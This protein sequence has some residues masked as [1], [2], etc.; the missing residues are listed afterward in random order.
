MAA[1]EPDDDLDAEDED[2]EGYYE[3]GLVIEPDADPF[4]PDDLM[5]TEEDEP[6]SAPPT[7]QMSL[8]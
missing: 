4:L 7:Q 6:P 1:L 8:F 5:P 3:E 2:D